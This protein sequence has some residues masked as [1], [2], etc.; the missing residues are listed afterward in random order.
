SPGAKLVQV[1]I[2]QAGLLESLKQIESKVIGTLGQRLI[3]EHG[4]Y[5]I[6]LLRG[7]NGVGE[8]R[9]KIRVLAE[10]HARR[11]VRHEVARA[12]PTGAVHSHSNLRSQG[13]VVLSPLGA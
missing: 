2:T 3:A 6:L 8:H 7:R 11:R 10:A 12:V 1:V 13:A 5:H 4:P 9:Q